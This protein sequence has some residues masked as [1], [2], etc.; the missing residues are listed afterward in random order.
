MDFFSHSDEDVRKMM[1]EL[2]VRHIDELFKDIDPEKLNPTLNLP[3]PMTEKEVSELLDKKAK[4]NC[5]DDCISLAGGGVYDTYIPAV[6]DEIAGR[7]EFYT[8]YTPYQAE[9][10]Q[11]TLQV[12][13]EFQSMICSLTGME[14]ANASMYDGASALAEAVLM[15]FRQK[16]K[17][18]T[19]YIAKNISP[20]YRKVIKTYLSGLEFKIEEI[21]FKQNGLID[22]EYLK[23]Q[24]LKNA[25]AIV[26]ANPNFFG[27]FET[28]IEELKTIKKENKLLLIAQLNLLSQTLVKGGDELGFDIV[29]GEAQNMGNYPGFGG[30]LLGFLAT[31]KKML[32]KLPGRIVGLSGDVDG[33]RAYVLTLQ[34]REQHIRRQSATS[35]ICSNEALCATRATIY[36]ALLG[37]QG[38]SQLA[39]YNMERTQKLVEIFKANG[40]TQK[41][42]SPYF[43]ENVLYREGIDKD[44]ERLTKNG[45]VCGI[46][47]NPYHGEDFKDC[48]LICGSEKLNDERL[49]DVSNILKEVL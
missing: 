15:A 28:E 25:S 24:D 45:L 16:K 33:K 41:F 43:N 3:E 47:L 37:K 13:Y 19:V 48:I 49:E 26:L 17:A 20:F 40:F 34:A 36:M 7:G 9:V 5:A 6:V 39:L 38:L 27:L 42:D 35:N 1:E 22:V 10:S 4:K 46:M 31:T 11:G 32:R 23:G 21:P 12:I 2:G 8:A 14:T 29:A 30:P 18:D 44:F